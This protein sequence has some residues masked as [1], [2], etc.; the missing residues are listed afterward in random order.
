MPNKDKFV[1]VTVRMTPEERSALMQ[2]AY[3]KGLETQAYC[4]E[5]LFGKKWPLK[6][7]PVQ[8][9]KGTND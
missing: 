4:Y 5:K 9:K 8:R 6:T 7:R 2:A 3:R 1:C